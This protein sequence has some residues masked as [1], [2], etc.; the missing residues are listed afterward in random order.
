MK[1]VLSLILSLSLVFLF[2]FGTHAEKASDSNE[3]RFNPDGT[4]KIMQINDTQDTDNMNKRTF[5][6]IKKAIEKEQPDLV[7]IVG[8]MLSDVFLFATK[9][10]IEKALN[11][12]G[13]IMTETKTPF[14][15]T[16]GNHDHDLEDVMST[17]EMMEILL[18]NEYCVSGT[19]GCD[20]GT[21]NLPVLK[22]GNDEY[23]MN[24]YMMDTNNKNKDEG[25]YQGVYSYQVDW[26]KQK[27]DELKSANSGKTVPSIL[28]QHIPPKE[29]YQL[30]QKVDR[31][32]ADSAVYSTKDNS[33]YKLNE[34]KILDS[35]TGLYEAPCSENLDIVTGQYEA[36]LE[37]GDI[38]GAFFGHDHVNNFVGKTDDG[39][40]LGYNGGTGFNTYGS[41]NK[42]SVRIYEFK[43]SD[44]ESYTTRSV[45]YDDV[46]DNGLDFYIIDLFSASIVNWLLRLVYKMFFIIPWC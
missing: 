28:F 25:S 11:C 15:V 29:V 26:Y 44:V 31:K 35:A 10:R 27:S 6:F 23:A 16:F 12:L 5:A 39:I 17:T 33:W 18:K 34:E 41:G 7:V 37:K 14:A 1:K 21:Y 32:Q 3:L 13:D 8:D 2:C 30:L 40:V 22:S 4:F 45:Y 9:G 19:D 24:I 36:W 46:L 38:L 20:A 42:R 43:E